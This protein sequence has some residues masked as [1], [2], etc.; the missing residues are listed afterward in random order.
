MDILATLAAG[1]IIVFVFFLAR[2]VTSSLENAIIL[3]VIALVIIV[4]LG[5]VVAINMT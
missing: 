4:V 5:V 3:S 2:K 1:A